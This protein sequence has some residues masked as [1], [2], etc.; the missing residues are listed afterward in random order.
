MR[1]WR[2]AFWQAPAIIPEQGRF[3]LCACNGDTQFPFATR[4]DTQRRCGQVAN[5][6]SDVC[7]AQLKIFGQCGRCYLIAFR[8]ELQSPD[9]VTANLVQE[10]ERVR[11][12]RPHLRGNLA[13]DLVIVR[14]KIVEEGGHFGP[15]ITLLTQR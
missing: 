5:D 7:V 2:C 10:A 11:A 9:A 1:G 8:Y 12:L 15:G 4:P 3:F 6:L 14:K 13:P